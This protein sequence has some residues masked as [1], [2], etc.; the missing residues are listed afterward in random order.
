MLAFHRHRALRH[1][2]AP[3]LPRPHRSRTPHLPLRAH[4]P[5]PSHLPRRVT[6]S[7]IAAAVAA[8]LAAAG[9]LALPAA[10]QR[11]GAAGVAVERDVMVEMRDGV[12]L[13]TDVYRPARDGVALPGRF[14][15]VL[16]RTPYGKDPSFWAAALVQHG[17]VS[18]M[19]DIRGRY[20]SQ[21]TFHGMH[22][23]VADGYDTARWIGAQPWCDGHIGMVGHSYEGG[24]QHSMA[25]SGAPYVS[26]LVP[27]DAASNA[28]RWG[29]RHDGAFELRMLN[30]AV[31][32]MSLEGTRQ[33]ADPGTRAAL[34]KMLDDL[35][36][37][38]RGLP[39]RRGTTPLRLVPE[40]E[41]WLIEVMTHADYDQFWRDQGVS[42]V[43]H[44]AEYKDI[45]VY[46][47]TGW[48]DSWSGPVANLSYPALRRAKHSLQRLIIGP[49]THGGQGN[50]FAGEADFGPAARLD[51]LQFNLR[52]FDRWLKGVRNGVDAEPPVRIFVM[53][54][55]DAH[56]TSEGRI[57]VGGAWRDE[58][59]WPPARAAATPYYLHADGE[60][61]TDRPAAPAPPT[62]FLADPRHPVPTLGGNIS[63]ADKLE[64]NG[65]M[66]QRCRAGLWTC[67]D[68]RPL[69]ARNDV[70]VFETAPLAADVEV[71]GRL[72]VHLYVSSSAIDTD[73]TAKLIDVFPP[74]AA[75]PGGFDLNVNDG[76]TRARYRESLATPKLLQPGEI[77]PLT[78]EMYPTSM[79]FKKG[80]RIRLDIAGSNFPRFDVN[81]NTGEPLG[82]NRRSQVAD[83]AVYHDA[84]HP[85]HIVLPIVPT[86][87]GAPSAVHA[88]ATTPPR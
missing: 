44:L 50:S 20:H 37:Y 36:D 12:R 39:L 18:V 28:G 5:G 8:L 59:D 24:T 15:V 62:H 56:R 78:V 42:V 46:H 43:D 29:I 60:L 87:P 83:N 82:M 30:W 47:V 70:L 80:H 64:D 63:A 16:A 26:A 86:L 27:M 6:P 71:T 45:P 3:A 72:V 34:Q 84:E 51:W 65:A 33:S 52:W 14:P 19:Q 55:G 69:S 22:A 17:Y 66:D 32:Y 77:V 4:L 9:L 73:F 49:W 48:Y 1:R 41:D 81:P 75:F 40:M 25:I 57:F 10:G 68:T 7:A 67:D 35:H 13:A 58:S 85:S 79:L 23:D 21:G 38:A 61:S 11:D 31:N 76:I 53:G 54:G 2:P 88:P 74:N